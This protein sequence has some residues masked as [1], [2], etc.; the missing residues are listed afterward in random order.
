MDG[1]TDVGSRGGLSGP[2]RSSL[3]KGQG[4][5][6]MADVGISVRRFSAPLKL[7]FC[8]GRGN[9]VRP[10]EGEPRDTPLLSPSLPSSPP[11]SRFLSFSFPF[12]FPH[13]H[14]LSICP[15]HPPES[16]GIHTLL[17]SGKQ[18]H[19][20]SACLGPSTSLDL[21][22]GEIPGG[23]EVALSQPLTGQCGADWG[24]RG[25]ESRV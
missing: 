10:D 20:S 24:L 16:V 5:Q 3:G 22:C 12:P 13:S 8:P 19:S 15:A 1:Q 23:P 7:R 6:A 11:C 17:V 21:P 18:A 4:S 14:F 25:S 9:S 2:G